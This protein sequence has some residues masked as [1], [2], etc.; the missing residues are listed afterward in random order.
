MPDEYDKVDQK[1][2]D[3]SAREFTKSIES[4][5]LYRELKKKD[6]KEDDKGGGEDNEHSDKK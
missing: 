6:T 1:I 4:G 3:R 2:I 5:A